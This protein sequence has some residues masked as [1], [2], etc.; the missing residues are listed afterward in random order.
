MKPG[1]LCHVMWF[2]V[3]LHLS[4]LQTFFFLLVG[5][6]AFV[7][8]PGHLSE[9]LLHTKS[10]NASPAYLLLLQSA[11]SLQ[12]LPGCSSSSSSRSSSCSSKPLW[13]LPAEQLL[14]WT[15]PT[16]PHLR[17]GAQRCHSTDQL[18]WGGV[19][20]SKRGGACLEAILIFVQVLGEVTYSL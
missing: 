19:S 16:V 10:Q 2:C 1:V 12:L 4:R 9:L 8:E 13:L 20:F 3:M 14:L 15:E 6:R 11:H 7:S 17:R 18:H 5:Q